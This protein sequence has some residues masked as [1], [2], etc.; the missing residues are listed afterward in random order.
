MLSIN[1]R[2][3]I[4][5]L[6]YTDHS[7]YDSFYWM[8]KFGDPGWHHHQ[9]IAQMWGL[10]ALRLATTPIVS[11]N[12]TA[13]AHKLQ[14]YLQSLHPLLPD[15]IEGVFDDVNVRVDLKDLE[16]A[17]DSL[18]DYARRLDSQAAHLRQ[19][20]ASKS[21]YFGVFCVYHPRSAER[22]KVN[23]A[24][25][26]FE[27]G[28]I[29]KGLPGRPIYKHVIYAPGT[30]EGYAGFT[31]PSIREALAERRWREAKEQVD[32]IAALIRTAASR[33]RF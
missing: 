6:T 10:T 26:Q 24:Y 21:C 5:L 15:N 27:R 18:G 22:R 29:G 28:F 31:L 33:T 14:R 12:A 7:N 9:Q 8:D 4:S 17:V 30:W 32:E 2:A 13:Y 11:F 23:E 25:L 19:N 16:D 20:P 3:I 1:V